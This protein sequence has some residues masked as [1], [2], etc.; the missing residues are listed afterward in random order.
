MLPKEKGKT[1]K[2][3]SGRHRV[4]PSLLGKWRTQTGGALCMCSAV[5][6]AVCCVSYISKTHAGFQ[7][8]P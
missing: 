8:I 4:R 1:R 6:R 2:Q 7:S 3:E 5:S